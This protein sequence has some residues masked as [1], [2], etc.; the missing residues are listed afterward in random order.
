MSDVIRCPQCNTPIEM[1]DAL[2]AQVRGELQQ[3]FDADIRHKNKEFAD[4]EQELQKRQEGLES[5]LFNRVQEAVGQKEES[6]KQLDRTLA[7]RQQKLDEEVTLKLEQQRAALESAAADKARK[8]MAVE[9]G[10]L[11]AQLNEVQGKLQE[12]QTTE[13]ALRKERRDLEQRQKDLELEVA[14]KIDAER[15]AIR[16]Q[17]SKSAADELALDMAE[18]DKLITD[19]TTQIGDLKRKAEQG[20]Q[21]T[22]GEVLEIELEK[23]LMQHFP[24]DEISPVPKGIHGGDVLHRVIDGAGRTCGTILWEAKRTKSWGRDWLAK[25]RDNQRTAKAQVAILVSI[26]LPKDVDNFMLLEDVWVSNRVCAIGLAHALRGGMLEIGKTLASLEGRQEKLDLVYNYLSS[27]EFKNRVAGI[28]EAFST[29]RKDLEAE[30]RATL[31]HWSK[32]EKQLELAVKNTAG[33]HGDLAGIMGNSLPAV[34]LLAL[35]DGP[36]GESDDFDS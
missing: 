17:A 21:Q 2:S 33:L 1:A 24:G 26:E 6:L 9:V 25:L 22:Q 11:T 5:E 19:L 29:M 30:K 20:S 32:R 8:S 4:R 35:P 31:R 36:V 10:D 16:E 23:L 3:K 28:V 7:D 13:V 14:R 15:Q 12:A 27:I 18:K 34:E